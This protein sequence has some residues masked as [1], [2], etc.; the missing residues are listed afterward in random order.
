MVAEVSA[1]GLEEVQFYDPFYGVYLQGVA[2]ERTGFNEVLVNLGPVTAEAVDG[3]TVELVTG[4][5]APFN[6]SEAWYKTRILDRY[7]NGV[8]YRSVG[9]FTGGDRWVVFVRN[10]DVVDGNWIKETYE[11]GTREIAIYELQP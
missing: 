10:A 11:K 9:A 3:D 8:V 7:L 1:P 5:N 6:Q 2:G 4:P